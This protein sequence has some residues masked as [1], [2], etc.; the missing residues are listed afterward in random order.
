MQDHIASMER[1]SR[2]YIPSSY[3]SSSNS[4]SYRYSDPSYSSTSVP[5]HPPPHPPP[6]HRHPAFPVLRDP[7][8]NIPPS[9]EDREWNLDRARLPVLSSNDPEVQLAWAQDALAYVQVAMQNEDRSA[10]IAPPRP[11]TPRVER[12][13]RTDAISIVNFLADQH[14]PRAE[15]IRG[16]WLEFGLFGYPVDRKEAFLCYSRA[17]ERG[18]PRAEYRVGMQFENANE[19]EKAIKY[20]EKG[21]ALGDSA[22]YYVCASIVDLCQRRFHS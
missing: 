2:G 19:P 15:F 3:S 20:Y 7:P 4:S 12:Q 13:I 14:H 1:Q 16:T 6:H 9:D 8:A 5:N 17:S 22:S 21:V 10:L 11:R 18:F